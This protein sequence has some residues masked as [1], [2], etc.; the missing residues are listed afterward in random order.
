MIA[1]DWL[2]KPVFKVGAI[3]KKTAVGKKAAGIATVR[4]ARPV[5]RLG[6]VAAVAKSKPAI[7]GWICIATIG[8]GFGLS[9]IPA[10]ND[11]AKRD[12]L[13]SIGS[14]G[15]LAFL[16]LRAGTDE[17]F[18]LQP[19]HEANFAIPPGTVEILLPPVGFAAPPDFPPKPQPE[20]PEAPTTPV[21]EPSGL[22]LL[23]A[24]VALLRAFL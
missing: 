23:A 24:A 20:Q 12:T 18:T 14:T 4:R 9:Q 8:G 22:L 3:V 16:P 13:P 15:P 5:R 6:K 17:F 7:V 11:A 2:C 21:P 1:L 10:S 19:G